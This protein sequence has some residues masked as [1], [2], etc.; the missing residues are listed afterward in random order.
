MISRTLVKGL[1]VFWGALVKRDEYLRFRLAE[2][3]S[4]LVYGTYKFSEFGRLFLYDEEFIRYYE[5]L[6]GTDNYHSLDRKYALDQFMKLA[7]SLEGDTAECGAFEGAS[8]YL[9]CRRIAGLGKKHHIFDSF[10]GLSAPRPEDGSYWKKGDLA[11]SES[12]IRKNLEPFH[13]V[14]YHKGWIPEKFQEVSGEKFCFVHLDVDLHEPTLRSLEFF[15]ER[16]TPGGLILCDD[17]GFVTCPGAR[18]AMDAFFSDK[19]E[20]V[21]LLPTGQGLVVK[22]V[23]P[24]LPGGV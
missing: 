11:G 10:E 21:I 7:L 3:L 18:K 22:R 16:M 23:P 12:V 6:V 2:K 14:V 4:G 20:E 15:Y 5:S 24:S 19:P 17:Y 13:F 1:R 9:I 8:S